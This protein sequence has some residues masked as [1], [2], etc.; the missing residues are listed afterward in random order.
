LGLVILGAILPDVLVIMV[1]EDDQ[2]IQTSVEEALSGGGFETAISASGEEAVTLLKGNRTYYQA[3]VTDVNLRGTMDGCEVAKQARAID[4]E[5][6]IR[7]HD[8]RSGRSVGLPRR[9]QQHSRDEAVRP[10]AACDGHLQSS[11]H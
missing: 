7:V 1:V 4:P 9:S 10:S 6:P 3:L 11:E 5:F 8:R 2:L